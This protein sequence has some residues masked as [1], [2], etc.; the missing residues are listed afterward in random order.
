VQD[1]AR[2]PNT[3]SVSPVSNG[4]LEGLRKLTCGGQH[5]V[6]Y[7]VVFLAHFREEANE[8]EREQFLAHNP[9]VPRVLFPIVARPT[10]TRET[11]AV[12][13]TIAVAI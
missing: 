13:A 6:G 1:S 4:R 8:R 11:R 10:R 5:P 9:R 7:P 3:W 2:E 12:R